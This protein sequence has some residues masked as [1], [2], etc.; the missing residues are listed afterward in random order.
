MARKTTVKLVGT[1]NI[2]G[3]TWR[4]FNNPSLN[5][6]YDGICDYEGLGIHL[7]PKLSKDQYAT[8]L[9]HEVGHAILFS[10]GLQSTSVSRDLEEIIVE[11]FANSLHLNMSNILKISAKR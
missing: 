11:A 4:V 5:D 1:L 2:F 10:V 6:E 8:T 7:S 3:K 9:L